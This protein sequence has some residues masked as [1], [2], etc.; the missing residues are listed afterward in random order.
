MN[1]RTKLI[2]LAV[3][4]IAG[5]FLAF[6]PN[7]DKKLE[8]YL[9][10]SET[11][12]IDR[13]IDGDT[14]E[15]GGASIRLLGINTPERG[16]EYY[17]EAKEF[18]EYLVLNKTVILEF[19]KEREDRYGRTLAYVYYEGENINQKMIEQG[20]A[21]MYFPSGKDINYNKFFWAWK[22]CNKN[23]CVASEDKCANCIQLKKFDSENEIVIFEN[24]CGFDCEL[25][26]WEIKDEGRKK[27][28][29]PKFILKGHGGI[30]II[31]GE[32]RNNENALYWTNEEYVWTSSGDTLFLRDDKGELVLWE[33]Y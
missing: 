25:T 1:L 13:V 33:I 7:L 22:E 23:L 26:N 24:I 12:F 14:I 28:V 17:I 11:A 9:I 31:V 10:S 18:L 16:E 21:N 8:G 20:Y 4:T 2:L 15:S 19:G 27:F 32:G 5:I 6:S 29:F 3:F 30:E